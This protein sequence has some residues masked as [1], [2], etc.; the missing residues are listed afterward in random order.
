MNDSSS[1]ISPAAAKWGE[2]AK[3]GFQTIP[4]VLLKNQAKL[5]EA[6]GKEAVVRT[7]GIAEVIEAGRPPCV[8]CVTDD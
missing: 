4:D 6:G 3:A 1:P 7:V 2:A 5:V 8:K